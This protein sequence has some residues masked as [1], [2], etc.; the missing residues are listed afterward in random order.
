MT[1]DN[2]L[3][4][5]AALERF[6]EAHPELQSATAIANIPEAAF[7]EKY[8]AEIEG[9]ER[10]ARR[11]HKTAVNVAERATLIWANIKDATS[12][13]FEQTLFNNI[14]RD[15]IDYH[16]SIPDYDRLF[17]NLDF[18][19]CDDCRSIFGPAAYFVDLMRFVEENITEN[20]TENNMGLEDAL[21]LDARRPDLARIKLDCDNAFTL[22]P[23]IDLI[24]EVLEA[25][26]TRDVSSPDPDAYAVLEDTD[27]PANL[28][29]NLPLAQIRSYL[30]QLKTS[31]NQL[32]QAF[33]VSS[34]A[35]LGPITREFL[36]LS[37]RE[38]S[39]LIAEIAQPA[40]LSRYYGTDVTTANQGG[41]TSVVNFLQQ[42]GL[43]RQ[44]LDE[45]VAQ[46]LNQDEINAGLSRLFFVNNVDDGLGPLAIADVAN[47]MPPTESLINLSAQKLDRIYRFVK[48]ARKLGWS[49]TDLDWA[50]RSLSQPYTPEPALKFDGVEDYVAC[51]NA[52][53]TLHNLDLTAFTIEAW[54]NPA[55]LKKNPIVA[56]GAASGNKTITHFL[57]WIDRDGRLGLYHDEVGVEQDS[58]P[59]FDEVRSVG[60]IP[61]GVFSHVAVAVD[62]AKARF[63]INGELDQEVVLPNKLTPLGADLHIGHNLN[64]S[65]FEGIIK[66]VRIWRGVRDAAWIASDGYHRLTGREIDLVGY[67]PL[68]L[69]QWDIVDDLSDSHNHGIP[70][71]QDLTTQ[72]T[73][74]L[75][76]L[77]LDPLPSTVDGSGPSF[78]FNGVD[79]YLT[80]RNTRGG[81]TAQLTVEI[82]INLD[83]LRDNN[84]ILW[85]GDEASGS[86]QFALWVSADGKLN[87]QTRLVAGTLTSQVQVVPGQ[88]THL[89]VSIVN[90]VLLI[91]V[92][93]TL[94]KEY[95]IQ[96]G[97]SF[98]LHSKTLLVGRSLDKKYYKG[99]LQELRLWERGRSSA[100]IAMVMYRAAPRGEPGLVGYWPLT[101]INMAAGVAVDLSYNANDLF[102]GGILEDYVPIRT[103]TNLLL[104]ALP[105]KTT[106]P[107]LHFDG[108]N[109]VI[110]VGNPQ[111]AGLGSYE[112]L[113]LQLWFR[114]D[115][116]TS[117]RQ[118]V[119]Y[120]QG[121]GEA[122]LSAYI[123]GSKLYVVVWDAAFDLTNFRATVFSTTA[124]HSGQWHH[125][126]VTSDTSLALDTVAL[127]AYLDGQQFGTATPVYT[128]A[129]LS[130]V[131]PAYLGG[132]GENA[133]TRF[134]ETYSDAR[135]R[136]LH[137]FA[138]DITDFRLSST[139]EI[140]ATIAT[141]RFAA[142]A[143]NAANLV[144]YL[145]L[146]EGQGESFAD[147]TGHGNTGVLTPRNMGL[148]ARDQQDNWD[149]VYAHYK[150]PA[151]LT[152]SNYAYTGRISF[153]DTNSAGGVT[154]LSRHPEHL[155]Q[156]YALW[157]SPADPT[158]HIIAHPLDLRPVSGW[159]QSSISPTPG[160]WYRFRVEVTDDAM[161]TAIK[162][163]VWAEDET[164]PTDFQ[165]NAND[166]S[167]LRVK[168][169]TVGIGA[170]RGR[171]VAVD[172]LQVQPLSSSAQGLAMPLL[173]EH[174][175]EF[176]TGDEPDSWSQTGTKQQIVPD[177]TLFTITNLPGAN[178][179]AF[180]SSETHSDLEDA[181]THFSGAG[182]VAWSN[183][184][185]QGRLYVG[186]ANAALG[187]T[188]LSGYPTIDAYYRI[189]RYQEQPSFQL[190]RHPFGCPMLNGKLD[191]G[192][193]PAPATWYRFRIDVQSTD[194]RTNIK[195]KLWQD[196]TAEP[197]NFQIDAYDD[198]DRRLRSGTVGVWTVGSGTR[199]V[200][201]LA[202]LHV[203]LTPPREEASGNN[204]D[205]GY[206]QLRIHG[207]ASPIWWTGVQRRDDGSN[208]WHDIWHG[209][210]D[211][212]DVDCL[213]KTWAI[214]PKDLFAPNKP[215]THCWFRWVVYAAQG[216]AWLFSS[217]EFHAPTQTRHKVVTAAT[218]NLSLAT[219][220]GACQANQVPDGWTDT[221]TR[222]QPQDATLLF[223]A[224]DFK[225]NRAQWEAQV[226]DY[227]LLRHPLN[228]KALHFNG[229]QEYAAAA[230]L[231]GL[232]GNALTL[233]AWINPDDASR[234]YPLATLRQTDTLQLALGIDASDKLTIQTAGGSTTFLQSVTTIHPG[235]FAHIVLSVANNQVTFYVNGTPDPAVTLAAPLILG[236]D[237]SIEIGRGTD[238]TCFAGE[239]KEIRVWNSAR[240]PA[241][242][243]AG[244][245][246]QPPL[247]A[248]DLVAYWPCG[249]EA[250]L[251]VQDA[252]GHANDLRLGG[253]AE[254]RWP[255]LVP[256]QAI[257]PDSRE[258][259]PSHVLAFVG[260]TDY[261]EL[262]DDAGDQP[263]ERRTVEVWFKVDDTTIAHRKQIIYREGD[264]QRGLII[265]VHDGTLYFGGYNLP[266]NESNWP[267]TWLRTDRI[268]ANIWH[269]AAL[270]LDG[271]AEI[272]PEALQAY[273]D[274][275]LVDV[276]D[277]SQL[278]QMGQMLTLGGTGEAVRFH[279]GPTGDT[280]GHFLVGQ[281]MDLRLWDTARTPAEIELYRQVPRQPLDAHL[282]LWLQAKDLPQD[283]KFFDRA[284]GGQVGTL[285][286]KRPDQWQPFAAPPIYSLP[287]TVLDEPAL[288]EIVTI[289]RLKD[290]LGVPLNQLSALWYTI[291]HTGIARG[292]TLWDQI[293]N[294]KGVVLDSWPPYLNQ[295]I[296]WE[297]VG[298]TDR[299]RKIR[300][301]LMAALHLAL[302]DLIMLVIRLSPGET[303]VELDNAYLTNLYRLA[304]IPGL[305]GLGVSDFLRLLDM[306]GITRIDR[307]DDFRQVND[308]AVWLQ[309][310]GLSVAQLDFLANDRQ[311]KLVSV[312]YNDAA[313]RDLATSLT[314]QSKDFLITAST[315]VSNQISQSQAL[316]L[317]TWLGIAGLIDTTGAVTA[318]YTKPGDLDALANQPNWNA[319][320]LNQVRSE[321]D[322]RLTAAQIGLNQ[323]VL[324]G[325]SGLLGANSDLTRVATTHLAPEMDIVTFFNKMLSIQDTLPIPADIAAYLYRLNKV[326]YLAN[327]FNLSAEAVGALLDYP[328]N[329]GV[330]QPVRPDIQDLEHLYTFKALN[331]AYPDNSAILISLLSRAN[332]DTAGITADV[333]ALTGWEPGQLAL[334]TAYLGPGGTDRVTW[335][336]RLKQCFDLAATMLV[337]INFLIQLTATD[338]TDYD[339]YKTEAASLLQVLRAGYDDNTW[340]GVYQ[341]IHD[342]LAVQQRDGL[343]SLALQQL[344]KDYQGRKDADILYEYLLLDVQTGSEVQTSRIVQA[345][346]SVQLYVQRCLMNLEK[347]V[348]P[349]SIPTQEWA[350]MQN[351]RVWEANRK[352]FLYPENYIEPELRNDKTPLFAQ[353]Q[354]D[355]T[356]GEMS[357]V[358][359]Q[360]AYVSYLDQFKEIASLKITGSYLYD[361][362]QDQISGADQ[363]LV[364]YLM[365]RTDTEPRT[366]YY[367][368][369]KPKTEQ[370]FPWQKID[371]QIPADFV[372]PVFAFNRL[373]LFWPEFIK[374]V[375]TVD[376]V[377]TP[378][379]RQAGK[380][381]DSQN[382]LTSHGIRLQENQDTWQ[383]TVKY[384][385][386]NFDKSWVQPQ[387]FPFFGTTGQ[388]LTTEQHL[389][390]EWQRVY[391]QQ[392]FEFSS[393]ASQAGTSVAPEPENN[394]KVLQ[395]TTDMDIQENVP[396]YSMQGLTWSFW[397]NFVNT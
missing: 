131:G 69:S 151:G 53:G 119:L 102:L 228:R 10:E 343:L 311:S 364:L 232:S 229:K 317:F 375:K 5:R 384:T 204:D 56:K 100:E 279:D 272:R 39:L 266:V 227:P 270:V 365:G 295:P 388:E 8:A 25:I 254:A 294:P 16:Q 67:W 19:E 113:T 249:E 122:G 297:V 98:D 115:D 74:V 327:Q 96:G 346:A 121:D 212:K 79:E 99:T 236:D 147:Q 123:A 27:F 221:A 172:D 268:T 193:T 226:T 222:N 94:D 243:A 38:F 91:Y 150:N 68:T 161:Q 353:L 203:D 260:S 322:T 59:T 359:V 88:P 218:V 103:D 289:K 319:T 349:E 14:P 357:Q 380:E 129:P 107:V 192:V 207:N 350:W 153:R 41:L 175:E 224:R 374:S 167:H 256:P 184:T 146:D 187:L 348:R 337:D 310:T 271:R 154:F 159:Q 252:S 331:A 219:N 354:Q 1:I 262:G 148:T 133:I 23:Y 70:G 261:V 9:G 152:W 255:T 87:C 263:R 269:Q 101:E 176:T 312:A 225:D 60:T 217:N 362:P 326:L 144:A 199:L 33:E 178:S 179:L 4:D 313:L 300:S 220:F 237:L 86:V 278:W 174:F 309:Q 332:G 158:F 386:F 397:V 132:I 378:A 191:S 257:A 51:N 376:K 95:T 163:K 274:G 135:T 303:I 197:T 372:S 368:Q 109:D 43:S 104:P 190:D 233:E 80:H 97:A 202:V 242:I 383:A 54:I 286:L 340:T 356:Q 166:A 58:N 57:F 318:R 328:A 188:F 81:A 306:L 205:W 124:I 183:Y 292:P 52:D 304:R 31:L 369:F 93:G 361:P 127:V 168:A 334:L 290:N 106:A 234:I 391:A 65:Y 320:Q 335:L 145:P 11:V 308:R 3:I 30:Q 173:V 248:P 379:D 117:D 110:T 285:A 344:G 265:Y 231:H 276:G 136:Y 247:P 339:F 63:Y 230:G 283:L 390:P 82:W 235:V 116:V 206:I 370:W 130:P 46:D 114:A 395:F 280:S 78:H 21:K 29:F 45:L 108:I 189:R 177:A 186:D 26:V 245:F 18:I 66:E 305:L 392:L 118:Q 120:S 210:L 142:P 37:P 157:R 302:P 61:A 137:Y 241:Q 90:G 307:L 264:D 76:D 259:H 209:H 139:A 20:I 333:L 182:A 352:V 36:E 394:A 75:Q 208:D 211:E 329:F 6:Q 293:F 128:H 162:A 64:D 358:T 170:A 215:A 13:F 141:E 32:Y 281:I 134:Q 105:I 140:V 371:A 251:I 17:R 323:A 298:N 180:G 315:F 273:L 382:Y 393:P 250:G 330:K 363:D 238:G 71:G 89:C 171:G 84:S 143:P 44:E 62:E 77:V 284:T 324:T 92:N 85:L 156:F 342:G 15:F 291:R 385:Y 341:P 316:A 396:N 111:G 367:R 22:I 28:P 239:V 35:N 73:W 288:V 244:Q 338:H 24:N 355:L 351:Y 296:R 164:E 301:R 345:I 377:A 387:T 83:E 223:E 195:A 138:G 160:I 246:V 2:M 169:G 49:F 258:L 126:A 253:L 214:D 389:R 275:K 50:V 155:D 366:Y 149:Y 165:M 34:G 181:H 194:T 282:V 200:D 185:Y 55:R 216:G 72:P 299:D 196:G 213:R 336:N 267:G 321:I 47:S 12:P 198:T 287:Q 201:S 360:K 325:L 240:T 125:L 347:G 112:R 42:I 373:F 381:I 7:V 40:D 314:T 48:L 277:G